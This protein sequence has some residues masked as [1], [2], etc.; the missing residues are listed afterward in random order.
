M[1]TNFY[2][3]RHAIKVKDI[4]DV[5]IT[6]EGLEQADLTAKHFRGMPISRIFVVPLTEQNKLP[7]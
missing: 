1:N 7:T 6:T 4:G 2:M 3:V 5:S